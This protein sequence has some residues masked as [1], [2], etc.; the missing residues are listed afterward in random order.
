M[1]DDVRT[2]QVFI[3]DIMAQTH[4]AMVQGYNMIMLHSGHGSTDVAY[5]LSA[6]RQ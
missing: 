5:Q 6:N 3:L 2:P 1:C 4:T